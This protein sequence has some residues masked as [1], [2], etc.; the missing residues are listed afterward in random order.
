[1]RRASIFFP[2][3]DREVPQAS[4]FKVT[5]LREAATKTGRT[6]CSGRGTRPKRTQ[7]S[8]AGEMRAACAS[9]GRRRL[10]QR[11]AARTAGGAPVAVPAETASV[12]AAARG[13]AVQPRHTAGRRLRL[14][15]VWK[16]VP[17]VGVPDG[18]DGVHAIREHVGLPTRPAC[19]DFSAL[20]RRRGVKPQAAE[21]H[22]LA[23][24]RLGGLP[25]QECAPWG[26]PPLHRPGAQPERPVRGPLG[27]SAPA[28]TLNT[29]STS[30]IPL[31]RMVRDQ[32][33]MEQLATCIDEARVARRLSEH[34]TVAP[35]KR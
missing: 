14:R 28:A 35:P 29:A 16:Q 17:S 4:Y 5:S 9:S 34:D 10:V 21:T 12:N 2:L 22:V 23:A 33:E 7:F 25:G 24:S 8:V 20:P 18:T 13:R 15:R 6:W 26:L 11:A 3:P 19:A 30:P 32:H 27:P 31:S 1:M